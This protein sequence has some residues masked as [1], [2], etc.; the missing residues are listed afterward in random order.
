M[1][2][3]TSNSNR[4]TI[5]LL[6]LVLLLAGCSD[7][8][9]KPSNGTT[10]GTSD[11]ISE[12]LTEGTAAGTTAD[13]TDGTADDVT[14]GTTADVTNG[15]A[16]V[17]TEIRLELAA[18]KTFRI[19]WE[20]REGAQSYRVFENPDGVAGFSAISEAL[21]S[22]SLSFDHRVALY[23]RVNA[24]YLVET[25]YATGC[26]NSEAVFVTGTLDDAVGYIK[27]SN[28]EG[29]YLSPGQNASPAVI[30]GDL[31]GSSISLS[32]DGK[33]LAVSAPGEGSAAMGVNGDQDDNTDPRSGAVYVFVHDSERWQQQAYLKASGPDRIC[34]FG[35]N[36][37]SASTSIS[38]SGDGN[39]LAVGTTR[40]D[41]FTGVI[42]VGEVFIFTRSNGEWR[43]QA[44]V[45]P[46]VITDA[47]GNTAANQFGYS[48]SL[49]SN[50]DT[51]VVGAPDERSAATG[52][53]G[54][55][56]DSFIFAAGS[57]YVFVRADGQ[58]Q[59]QAYLKASNA[60]QFHQFGSSVAISADGST[61]V[62]GALGESSLAAGVMGSPSSAEVV[63]DFANDKAGAAYVFVR[64]GV[65]WQ[66]QAFI[67]ASN[68]EGD[69]RFGE[70]VTLSAD[71]NTL[72]VAASGEDG[73]AKGVNGDQSNTDGF[74]SSA[75]GAVYV[76]TRNSGNWEQQAY[77][78]A[79]NNGL[80]W[81]AQFGSAISIS[82]DGNTLA[83]GARGEAGFSNGING[84]Q[85]AVLPKPDFGQP[86]GAIYIGAA[87]VFTRSANNWQQVAYVK[88]TNNTADV[89]NIGISF[90]EAL[91]L[92][93]DGQTLVVGTSDEA[94]GATG[95]NGDR[96]DRSAPGAGAVFVY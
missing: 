47:E 78:K 44:T 85:F 10:G 68:P 95:I 8:D 38:L 14:G 52:D 41:R 6:S 87:Y 3:F 42:Y 91:S 55:Q 19:T 71:G 46:R 94:G 36:D 82:A 34:C 96:F 62:V 84:D 67:K 57:A 9:N 4:F 74:N 92:S 51:L 54:N 69:D 81:V 5:V 80:A 50:G 49:S 76:F 83:V 72:A 35:G 31:F 75:T 39:T 88:A 12:D 66:Q 30:G 63:Q 58:W 25:C 90:G 93:G 24:S 26:V 48:V 37:V 89:D 61:I 60:G 79:S 77:L 27:A 20:P 53:N 22:S 73:S 23:L 33:T 11:G 56:N 86:N 18:D 43:Q 28:A 59:E 32:A 29:G 2:L 65:S 16:E 7:S 15:T 17:A 1:N 70:A 40:N 45:K 21:D 13:V 64:S